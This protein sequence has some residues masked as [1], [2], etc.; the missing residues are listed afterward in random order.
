[1]EQCSRQQS[2]GR[3]TDSY[4]HI[5]QR[6]FPAEHDLRK[7]LL[8]GAGIMEQRAAGMERKGMTRDEKVAVVE[9]YV[10][11]L[12]NGDLSGVPFSETV[13][14]HG[15]LTDL[16][17]QEAIDFLSGLSPVMRGAEILQHIVEGEYVATLFILR[18]PNGETAVFDKFRVVDGE[19]LDINPYYDPTILRDALSQSEATSTAAKT[20]P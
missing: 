12:G 14:F 1:M 2:C 18:T 10:Y 20:S 5:T 3:E 16:T 11:G 6:V 17:G 9:K 7:I 19:L 15:P 13:R 4:W 8:S